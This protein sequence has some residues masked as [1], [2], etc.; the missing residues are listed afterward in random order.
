MGFE[1]VGV[2]CG[3]IGTVIS[4]FFYV[5]GPAPPYLK[6]VRGLVSVNDV[7]SLLLVFTYFNCIL[8]VCYGMR[9]GQFVVWLPVFIGGIFTL[10]Y[11]SIY[12]VF[13]LKK[14]ILPSVVA[15]ILILNLTFE[16]FWIFY[17]MVKNV[18]VVGLICLFLIY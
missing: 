4:T 13:S 7:P 15:I 14:K 9:D 12:M 10:L 3:W 18:K 11:I 17:V 1:T 2:V 6:L 8:W 16:I 5:T